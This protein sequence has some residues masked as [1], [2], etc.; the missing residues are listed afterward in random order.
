MNLPPVHSQYQI[1]AY[2]QYTLIVVWIAYYI[3]LH[4]TEKTPIDD[5]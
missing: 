4:Q 5:L 1:F 2:L 3:M